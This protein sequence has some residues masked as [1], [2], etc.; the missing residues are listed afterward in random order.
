M[1]I[2]FGR[3]FGFAV[4]LASSATLLWAEEPVRPRSAPVTF[5]GPKSD[6]VSTN[7]NDLRT[8]IT[9]L[10]EMEGQLKR[11][12]QDPDKSRPAPNFRENRRISQQG[13]AA[14]QKSF[15]ENLNQRAE[16][17]FLDPGLYDPAKEDEALFQLDKST[18]KKSKDSLERA[19][20]LPEERTRPGVTN[21][22][23]AR[24]LFGEKIPERPDE[25]GRD[26]KFVKPPKNGRYA[27]AELDQSSGG[28]PSAT[29]AGSASNPDRNPAARSSDRSSLSGFKSPLTRPQS[30]AESRLEE[31]KKL[32]EGPRATPP[33]IA[34]GGFA[35]T[36]AA[37][38]GGPAASY[39][40]P[41]TPAR[42][43]TSP[44]SSMPEWSAFRSPTKDQPQGDFARSAG[45]VGKLEKPAGLPEFPAPTASIAPATALPT[46]VTS[47]TP[48][49]KISK[50]TFKLPQRGF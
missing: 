22:A 12:F 27:P 3:Q 1:K 47:P 36:P 24:N 48:A 29:T 44:N 6:A 41:A 46:M 42:P 31:F 17:M 7:L 34:R 20:G 30:G 25:L 9:P 35:T 15:K 40:S 49:K 5:S 50:P 39:S 45:L 21:Q 4:M 38:Y 10:Q 13:Q 16:A 37:N 14:R 18:G 26:S 23:R 33:P 19:L 8:P 2:G 43:A 11:S 32:L 28:L